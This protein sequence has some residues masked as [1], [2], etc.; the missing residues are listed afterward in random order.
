M[1]RRG[2]G[3]N[4]PADMQEENN[5]LVLKDVIK[6]LGANK[7]T[8]AMERASAAAPVVAETVETYMHNIGCV[9]RSGKHIT[10]DN[11]EDVTFVVQSLSEI[12]PFSVT[13]NRKMNFYNG[14]RKNPFSCISSNFQSHLF[15]IVE[16]LKRGQNIDLEYYNQ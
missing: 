11:L 9:T 10:K 12:D 5:I 14:F 4:K 7:T 1:E 15:K 2:G 3:G 16:R 13:D 6:G 8:K